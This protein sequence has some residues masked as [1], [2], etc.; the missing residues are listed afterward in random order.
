MPRRRREGVFPFTR[1]AV[2]PVTNPLAPRPESMLAPSLE[3]VLAPQRTTLSPTSMPAAG[4]AGA[5][6]A[7]P[8]PDGWDPWGG[9]EQ[10]SESSQEAADVRER[11]RRDW[12]P[13]PKAGPM[14]PPPSPQVELPAAPLIPPP[15]PL[16]AAPLLS[17]AQALLQDD[18]FDPRFPQRR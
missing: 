16:P 8:R 11:S 7:D 2:S 4:G 17:L 3:S 18:G 5:L 10:H 9:P 12:F 1:Q 14:M 15:M 6:G 13:E